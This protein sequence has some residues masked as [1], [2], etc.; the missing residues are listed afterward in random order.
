MSAE[1]FL[2]KAKNSFKKN[3]LQ[4]SKN[5]L[6][7]ILLLEKKNIEALNLMGIILGRENNFIGA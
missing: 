4:E 7:K 3:L 5:Y 1:E 2:I 6:N